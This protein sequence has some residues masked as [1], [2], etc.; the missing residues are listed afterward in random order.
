[1]LR[2]VLFAGTTEGRALCEY[3]I[4]QKIPAEVYVATEYGKEV[5]PKAEYLRIHAGRLDA[6]EMVLE[7]RRVSPVMVLDATHPYAAAVTENIYEACKEAGVPYLRVKREKGMDCSN[8]SIRKE[9]V[10]SDIHEAVDCLNRKEFEDCKIL[11]TTGSKQ[12]KAYQE[13]ANYQKRIYV[14][15]LPSPQMLSACIAAGLAPAQIICMQGP[16]SEEFNYALLRQLGI[17]VLVTKESGASGG[18]SE[19]I[20]AAE[21]AGIP[22]IVIKRPE[23]KT[24]KSLAEVFDALDMQFGKESV[25]KI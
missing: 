12:L 11:L 10:V 3:C 7:L 13:I 1:M 8:S 2:I 18:F 5:L 15:I 9:I 20:R 19:K 21:R 4:R 14:R 25:E 24:G 6:W 16:F 23:E 17:D 22:V